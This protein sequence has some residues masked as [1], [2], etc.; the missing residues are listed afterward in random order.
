MRIVM[1]GG[2][3]FL[4]YFTCAELLRRSHEVVAVGLRPPAPGPILPF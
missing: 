4:G 2:T 3:G 1:I